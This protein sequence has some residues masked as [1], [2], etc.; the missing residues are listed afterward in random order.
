MVDNGRSCPADV[1]TKRIEIQPGN[2]GWEVSWELPELT[3]PLR[4]LERQDRAVYEKR[5]EDEDLVSD[6]ERASAMNA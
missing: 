1:G 6:Q 5:E 4:S 3:P 2:G